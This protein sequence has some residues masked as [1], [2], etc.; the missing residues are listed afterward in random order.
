MYPGSV[1]KGAYLH[2]QVPADDYDAVSGQ[3]AGREPS[4]GVVCR[5]TAATTPQ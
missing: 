5:I 2:S 1:N 4:D 3:P